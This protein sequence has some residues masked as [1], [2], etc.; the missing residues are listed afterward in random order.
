LSDALNPR[1]P[2]PADRRGAALVLSRVPLNTINQS[3]EPVSAA[4]ARPVR[5]TRHQSAANRLRHENLTGD[6]LK[7]LQ[8]AASL[9]YRATR[10]DHPLASSGME[11]ILAMEVPAWP[12]TDSTGIAG[13]NPPHGKRESFLGR[14][15]HRQR[16]FTEAGNSVSP[17]T[18]RKYLPM[19]PPGR[20][21]GD[22]RWSTFLRRHVRGI[23]A[24]D[25]LVVV[26]ATFRLLYVFVVIEHRSRRLVHCNVTA[27]PTSAWTLQQLREAA[28]FERRYEYLLHDRDRIFAEH[29]DVSVRRLGMTVLKSPPHC[30]KANAICE[31]VIGTI[32]RECLD[33]LIPLSESH[34]RS[35]LKSWIPHY[36]AGRPHMAL[37]PGIPDPPPAL[38]DQQKASSRRRREESYA[39]HA[40]SILDGLHHEYSF[41]PACA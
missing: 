24:C 22:V 9:S 41:A 6:T 4:A 21:R 38:R 15:A 7:I 39:V 28:E 17:R 32:R 29:L 12:A 1:N 26:I 11:I 13:S 18:V 16:A 33:W 5:R 10:D 27:H 25:F 37:G 30:P 34:L 19:R 40:K 23:I 3:R 2:D 31:R 36:N 20:P 14:G 35:I 8:L